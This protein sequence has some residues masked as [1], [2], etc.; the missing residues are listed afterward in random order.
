MNQVS[1]S[2][3]DALRTTAGGILTATLGQHAVAHQ[4]PKNSGLIDVHMHIVGSRLPGVPVAD[5]DPVRLGPFAKDDLQGPQRLAQAIQDQAKRAN[6]EQ[7]LCMPRME[8]SDQDPLGISE[9]LKQAKLLTGIKI[10]P[11]GLAHPERFDRDH[12]A[13][14]EEILKQ[15]QVKGFKAYLGY[16]HY[17]ATHLGYRAY[18]KL[19]AKYNLP[20]IL[21]TGDTYSKT[22]KVKHAH[23]LQMDELAVDFPDTKFV[24]AHFGN[25]WVLDAAEVAYKNKNVWVDIS[26]ILIGDQAYF[27]KMEQT[28]VVERTIKRIREGI[29]FTEAPEKFLFGSDWPL[30]PVDVYRDFVR[31]LFPEEQHAG[32][33]SA[34]AKGLFGL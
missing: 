13:R 12:L 5:N 20:V 25:P 9:T 1:I 22:A 11:I 17:D 33:F 19:A 10:H 16:L 21:H 7:A 15:G 29:E 27:E 32:V 23:P 14:V 30:A 24:L 6:V 3:R 31:R 18:Y 26:A 2:R 34:N 28:G 8:I 4:P